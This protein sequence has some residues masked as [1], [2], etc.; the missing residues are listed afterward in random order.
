MYF[1]YIVDDNIA[2]YLI[3]SQEKYYFCKDEEI[4]QINPIEGNYEGFCD[5]KSTSINYIYLQNY[6]LD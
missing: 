2:I 3:Y 5:I 1:I 6:Q 4:T